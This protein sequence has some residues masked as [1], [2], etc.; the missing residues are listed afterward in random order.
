MGNTF[1]FQWEPQ[2]MIWLQQVMGP[3][4]TKI[5][6]VITL[7]GEEMLLVA[8]LG[9]LY[10]CYDKKY[11]AYVGTNIVAGVTLNGLIKNI[12]LRRRPY[13]D[14]TKIQCLKAPHADTDI[15]DVSV[16]GYSFPSGHS[17][18]S[19]IV[20]GSL[21]RY[22]KGKVLTVLA[23]VV[24]FL[25][26]LSRI[27]LGV[28]YPTDVLAGWAGGTVLVF[29]MPFLMKKMKRWVLHL[30]LV[31][32]ALPG[33][34]YCQT[35]DYFTGLGL[36]IGFFLALPFEERFVRFKNL[37][38]KEKKSYL[39]AILRVLGGF[40]VYLAMNTLLKLPFSDAFLEEAAIGAFLVRTVRYAVVTF[41]AIGVYP[42]VFGF[43]EK[44]RK[45]G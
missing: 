14:H 24:P 28:H 15:Y 41:T 1:Y 5:M 11:A 20:Y 21:A 36:M 38:F 12:W 7:F 35:N 9:F 27:M 18:N 44:D 10:W 39:W 13:M 16:Q 30:V 3:A 33:V 25:V 26:G 43:I 19:A 4:L 42:M 22:S 17:M 45:R 2:L 32:L 29:L 8:V 23:F 31:I 6:S 37:D 34:F 40:A